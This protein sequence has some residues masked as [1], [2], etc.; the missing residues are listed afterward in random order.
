MSWSMELL[1]GLMAL[2]HLLGIF[3]AYKAMMETRTSQG[4]IAWVIFLLTF[5]YVAVPL[6]W[7]FGR[8][9][10]VGYY[11]V[12]ET[13]DRQVKGRLERLLESLHPYRRFQGNEDHAAMVAE[14]LADL[15][16]TVG[17]RVELLINGEATFAS[18]LEGIDAA[19]E[20]ILF[21]FYIVHD[22]EI[23]N[24]MADRLI[25]ATQR[26]VKV[27]F[28]YDEIGS[29]DLSERYLKRLQEAGIHTSAFNTRHGWRNKFQVNFRNHRKVVVVDGKRCWVGGH[30]VGDE[31]LGKDPKMGFWRDTHVA[32]E[33]PAVM[34]AQ[35]SFAEDW[36]WAKSEKLDALRWD[37]VVSSGE[38]AAQ[39]IPTGP[40]DWMDTA[41]LMYLHAIDQAKERLWIASPYFVPDDA[42]VYALQLAGLRGVDVRILIPE[43]SD[44][45]PVWL[46][47]FS[48]LADAG[49]T[50]VRFFR[51]QK[52][53]L[54][55][56]VM[57][58][59]D[60]LATVGTANFDNRSF[61]LNFEI[62]AIVEDRKFA[63]E[64]EQ[65]FLDDFTVSRE[66]DSK[67][68]EQ[69]PWWFRVGVRLA[70][71]SAPVL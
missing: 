64:V 26:G 2:M 42:V 7:I 41:E 52:G 33:G 29:L 13:V 45:L 62:T 43:K 11:K 46:A 40:A 30:N 12:K 8:S 16:F 50:G 44:S 53:F 35:I 61:R 47:A 28:L 56:K 69:K 20:Y 58:I 65:M 4:A 60:Q 25:A 31:Y 27:W 70:R 1:L 63:A 3:S 66:I 15:P 67:I 37:P 32:I 34:G 57:L 39:V 6:Y 24:R 51:Y 5:P 55:E 36:Y 17:N 49:K 10:F 23:G 54:H 19:K 48:Y 59:D 14:K 22:D 18:I 9:R 68:L 71:L 21:Q 38:A